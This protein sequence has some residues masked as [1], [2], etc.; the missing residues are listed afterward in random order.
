MVTDPLTADRFDLA[1]AR[2]WW[3]GRAAG[4]RGSLRG[5]WRLRGLVRGADVVHAHGHQAGLV[6]ASSPRAR[7]TPL[8]VSQHNAVLGRRVRAAVCSTSSSASWPAGPRW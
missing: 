5:L 4:L 6:A 8:V 7:G 3:P 2:L 1:D